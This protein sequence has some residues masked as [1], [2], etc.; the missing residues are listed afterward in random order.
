MWKQQHIIIVLIHDGEGVLDG[1]LLVQ[2]HLDL[3]FDDD[4]IDSLDEGEVDDEV[5]GGRFFINLL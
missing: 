3:V 5:V 4:I 2:V 1:D